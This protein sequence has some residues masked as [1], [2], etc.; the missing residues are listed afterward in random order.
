MGEGEGRYGSDVEL[1]GLDIYTPILGQSPLLDEMMGKLQ[2]RIDR[3]LKFQRDLMKLRGALDMT[4]AQV[5]PRPRFCS[6][7]HSHFLR[8]YRSGL[9]VD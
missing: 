5:R 9:G 1:T 6:H 7:L 2:S 4:L 3:E 8:D